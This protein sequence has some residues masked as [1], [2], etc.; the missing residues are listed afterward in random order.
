MIDDVDGVKVVRH[1]ADF[2][3][4]PTGERMLVEVPQTGACQHNWNVSFE[5]DVKAGKCKCLG[6]G[7][8]VS[9]IFVLEELM[10]KESQWNRSRTAYIDEMKRLAERSSTKCHA[11]GKMTRISS[12]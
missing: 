9:P 11:C 12:R 5:V 7:G 8:E 2:K 6:C 3:A 10:K 1:T 4:P